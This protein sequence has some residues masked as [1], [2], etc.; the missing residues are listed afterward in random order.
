M[1]YAVIYRRH[2][3]VEECVHFKPWGMWREVLCE[4]ACID[5]TCE[6][7]SVDMPCRAGSASEVSRRV[8]GGRGGAYRSDWFAHEHEFVRL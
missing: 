2:K 1:E 7:V 8:S 4:C 6:V 3:T 5:C